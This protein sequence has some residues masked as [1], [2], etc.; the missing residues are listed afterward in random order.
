MLFENRAKCEFITSK[1]TKESNADDSV[2][3]KCE[4]KLSVSEAEE[5]LI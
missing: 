5:Q 3:G 4:V 2:G 1:Q